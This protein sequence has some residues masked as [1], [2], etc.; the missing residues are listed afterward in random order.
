[1]KVITNR[2]VSVA[3]RVIHPTQLAFLLGRNIMEGAIIIHETIHELH[4]IKLDGVILKIDFEKV[5]DKVKWPFVKHVMQMK[6][7][8]LKWCQWIDTIIKGDHVAIKI[9]DQV[10][11]NFQRKKG[12]RQGTHYHHYYLTLWSICWPSLLIKPRQANR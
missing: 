3:Q 11:L 7:F 9:N 1:M 10:G 8:S 4:R 12:L 2:L 6:G 5:Y